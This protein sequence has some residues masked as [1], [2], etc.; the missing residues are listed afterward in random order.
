[1]ECTILK[2][3]LTGTPLFQCS[4]KLDY[5]SDV[6]SITLKNPT[7]AA[8]KVIKLLCGSKHK[9]SGN[10]FFGFRRNDVLQKII[11][12]ESVNKTSVRFN[13]IGVKSYGTPII[14]DERY[15][16]VSGN[17]YFRLQ[18]GF[19]SVRS[20]IVNNINEFNI[21]CKI[22]VYDEG[23]RF[24]CLEENTENVTNLTTKPTVAMNE[25]FKLLNIPKTRNRS[26]YE[27][28]GFNRSDVL[29]VI[30]APITSYHD[31]II[32]N[33]VISNPNVDSY[34]NKLQAIHDRNAGATSYLLHKKS[35]YA[36]NNAIH[37]AVKFTS[38]NDIESLCIIP[39]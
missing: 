15:R 26:G 29:N 13:W 25:M 38:F 27:F 34:L 4:Y 33:E 5:N 14:S 1:M 9:W 23:P 39:M 30:K 22:L 11:C 12:D 16:Y 2:S 18:P 31:P 3:S 8:N 21:H 36:R 6:C 37:D 24:Q 19:E 20:V 10:E 7:D 17:S 32:H 35:K 28:F